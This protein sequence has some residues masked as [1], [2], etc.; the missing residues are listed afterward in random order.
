MTVSYGMGFSFLLRR[1]EY[2]LHNSK[3]Y[4]SIRRS[5]IKFY[6]QA[7]TTCERKAQIQRVEINF[8]GCKNDQAEVVKT[9]RTVSEDPDELLCKVKKDEIL[10]LSDVNKRITTPANL[11]GQDSSGFSTDSLQIGGATALFAGGNDSLTIKR[12]WRWCSAVFERYP[13]IKLKSLQQWHAA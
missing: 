9:H 2:L 3:I 4:Q 1:S 5:D 12:F 7:G 6:K 10:R 11:A 13:R 8:R